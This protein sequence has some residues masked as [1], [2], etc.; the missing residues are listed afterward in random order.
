MYET[1]EEFLLAAVGKADFSHAGDPEAVEL[2]VR[3]VAPDPERR[4]LY[5]GCG[6]GAG[7]D[8]LRRLGMGRVTAIDADAATIASARERYPEVSFRR[9]DISSA[10]G[11]DAAEPERFD[12]LAGFNVFHALDDHARALSMLRRMA[13]DGARLIAIDYVDM[14]SY[15]S[16]PSV[17]QAGEAFLR[18]P[19][20]LQRLAD[21]LEATGWQLEIQRPMLTDYQDLHR[22]LVEGLAVRRAFIED[23]LGV[24]AYDRAYSRYRAVLAA[25]EEGCLGGALI[26][27]RAESP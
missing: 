11:A 7:A 6:D 27:A 18:H 20:A 24:S 16:C 14:G 8:L 10:E 21:L 22:K 15:S 1:R 17:G 3:G 9:L 2:L 12:L 5:I 13:A 19:L 25:L 26:V 23:R 4:L